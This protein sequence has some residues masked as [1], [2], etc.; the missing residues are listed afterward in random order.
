MC[1]S[2]KYYVPQA[3][4]LSDFSACTHR[5]LAETIITLAFPESLSFLGKPW[6]EDFESLVLQP[7]NQYRED[8]IVRKG[9]FLKPVQKQKHPRIQFG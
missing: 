9:Q 7:Q 4:T 2:E 3:R 8:D 5:A 1:F 6:L